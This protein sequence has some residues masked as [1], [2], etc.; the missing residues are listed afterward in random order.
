MKTF[1]KTMLQLAVVSW[2]MAAWLL[3]C[4]A[5]LIPARF[6]LRSAF[7]HWQVFLVVGA[8]MLATRD[9][10]SDL[11][12]RCCGNHADLSVRALVVSRE[13]LCRSCLAWD[14]KVEETPST[15][16]HPEYTELFEALKQ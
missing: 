8:V 14:P 4:D 15:D 11:R 6:A 2:A 1:E 12:C 3:V 5:N 7:L 13:V 10:V 16:L 9:Q